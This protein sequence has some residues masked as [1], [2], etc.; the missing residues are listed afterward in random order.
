MRHHICA[1]YFD[2]WWYWRKATRWLDNKNNGQH[3]QFLWCFHYFA[4]IYEN[5]HENQSWLTNFAKNVTFELCKG[6]LSQIVAHLWQRHLKP[7]QVYL[8]NC[9]FWNLQLTVFLTPQHIQGVRGAF[10]RS[11]PQSENVKRL[12]NF[13]SFHDHPPLL[14]VR[15]IHKIFL[16][17]L[18]RLNKFC[19]RYFLF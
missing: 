17:R 13:F 18:F 7:Y 19:C 9:W 3:S 16:L 12:V 6:W 2:I 11:T 1:N 15:K 10:L 14:I 4:R 8:S 5:F